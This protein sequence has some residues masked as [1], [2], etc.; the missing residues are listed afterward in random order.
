MQRMGAVLILDNDCTTCVARYVRLPRTSIQPVLAADASK[1]GL[2]LLGRQEP[3]SRYITPHV[4][5]Y[6][7]GD[8]AD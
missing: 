3:W 8:A 2:T 1:T 7:V 4:A 5:I 6:G